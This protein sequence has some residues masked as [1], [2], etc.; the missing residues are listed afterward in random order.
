MRNMSFVEIFW[1]LCTKK[2]LQF[3]T[4]FWSYHKWKIVIFFEK[5]ILNNWKKTL[6]FCA[7]VMEESSGQRNFKKGR[8]NKHGNLTY[9]PT[10]YARGEIYP[11]SIF[12]GIV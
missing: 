5:T 8:E 10:N 11:S 4:F 7:P 9:T 6:T 1:K 2:V 12:V 3:M